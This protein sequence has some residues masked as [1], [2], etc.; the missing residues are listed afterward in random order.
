MVFE[1][2][3][4]EDILK[5]ILGLYMLPNLAYNFV[6]TRWFSIQIAPPHPEDYC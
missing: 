4:T 3:A 2:I 1:H 5:V 6:T